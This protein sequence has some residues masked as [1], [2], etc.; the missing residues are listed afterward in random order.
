MK[1]VMPVNSYIRL[2]L[3]LLFEEKHWNEILWNS[4]TRHSERFFFNLLISSCLCWVFATTRAFS[5]VVVHGPLVVQWPLYSWSRLQGWRA[6]VVVARGPSSCAW[7]PLPQG[8]WDPPGSGIEPMSPELAGGFFATEPPGKPFKRIFEHWEKIQN[9]CAY[10]YIYIMEGMF[11]NSLLFI[12]SLHFEVLF[13][14]W[15]AT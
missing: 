9:N 15:I 12:Y 7:A 5:L 2:R 1:C 3:D 4:E 8:R 14:V 11:W 13:C 6:S 10:A